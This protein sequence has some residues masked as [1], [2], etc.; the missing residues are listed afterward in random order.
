MPVAG[1]EANHGGTDTTPG[2]MSPYRQVTKRTS[3]YVKRFREFR[4]VGGLSGRLF[5]ASVVIAVWKR[6]VSMSEALLEIMERSGLHLT[7]LT[8]PK[9]HNCSIL[10]TTTSVTEVVTSNERVSANK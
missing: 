9:I 1:L 5:I 7:P 2:P 10:R 6:A 4:F 8:S 3:D